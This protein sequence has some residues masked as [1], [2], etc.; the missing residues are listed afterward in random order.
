MEIHSYKVIDVKNY[1]EKELSGLYNKNKIRNFIYMIFE[2]YSGYSK[3]ELFINLNNYI[4]KNEFLKIDSAIQDLKKYKPIQYILGSTNFYGLDFIVNPF[5]FIPRPE[6]E[7]L[8]DYILKDYK[9]N[10]NKTSTILDVG[11]GSACIAVCLKKNIENSD[12]YAVDI[13]KKALNIAAKNAKKNNVKISFS[14]LDI[15]DRR[16]WKKL[17]K[18]DIIVSNPPYVMQSEKIMMDKN[19]LNYEPSEALFVENDNALIFYDAVADFALEHLNKDGK[20][21]FEINE[22]LSSE[23]K[24]MLLIKG[25]N[26]IKIIKDIN[27]KDR[28]AK[29]NM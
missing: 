9:V 8:V 7:E 24:Q 3:T 21:Y 5:V 13:S 19:I 25:F 18:F 4:D 26:Y 16:K 22:F 12:V 6:T 15:L 10:E 2:E 28:I 1:C 11:T 14:N 23:L 20:I 27:D 17:H 29:I